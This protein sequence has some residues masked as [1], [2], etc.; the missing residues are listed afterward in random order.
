M[1][2]LPKDVQRIIHRYLHRDKWIRLRDDYFQNISPL[3][4]AI[5][6]NWSG[7]RTMEKYYRIIRCKVC[8]RWDMMSRKRFI[9]CG[10]VCYLCN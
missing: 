3:A 9:G 7:T 5:I 10:K 2:K 8:G 1:N 6:A 4:V